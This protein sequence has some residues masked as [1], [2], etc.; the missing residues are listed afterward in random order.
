VRRSPRSMPS[1]TPSSR[2]TASASRDRGDPIS[3]TGKRSRRSWTGSFARRSMPEDPTRPL[4]SP[5][6]TMSISCRSNQEP[7]SGF[8]HSPSCL[9]NRL[10]CPPRF[11]D[12]TED[13]GRAI[14]GVLERVDNGSGVCGHVNFLPATAL[15]PQAIAS[16]CEQVRVRVLRWFARSGLTDSD[17]VREMLT[18]ENSGF[19]LDAEVPRVGTSRRS[20]SRG[21]RAAAKRLCPPPIRARTSRSARRSARC[22]SLAQSPA[23][24][25]H[26]AVPH[27]AGAD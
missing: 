14:D 17:D 19:S 18:R 27:A 26:A 21:P 22:L 9:P 4:W 13:R 25:K 6:P 7:L 8:R 11:L 24:R 2:A 5:L 1:S 20:G 15:T 16:V 3:S 23:G 10:R 12:P